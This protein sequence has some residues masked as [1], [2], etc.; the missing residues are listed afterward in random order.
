MMHDFRNGPVQAAGHG[1]LI[2]ICARCHLEVYSVTR[3]RRMKIKDFLT[4][5]RLDCDEVIMARVQNS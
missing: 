1:Y 2:W 3:P 4:D 5:K